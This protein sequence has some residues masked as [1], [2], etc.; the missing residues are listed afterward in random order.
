MKTVAVE[1]TSNIQ[2]SAAGGGAPQDAMRRNVE[3][4]Q[5]TLGPELTSLGI[6]LAFKEGDREGDLER[7]PSPLRVN[8]RALEEV[9]PEV[10]VC[11]RTTAGGAGGAGNGAGGWVITAEGSE[12]DVIPI[13]LIRRA[14]LAAAGLMQPLRPSSGGPA[15]DISNQRRFSW[16]SWFS[17]RWQ[18]RRPSDS[19]PSSGI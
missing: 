8:E 3:A 7:P 5:D 13:F 2:D 15:P 19:T 17:G 4:V 10:R 1:W 16:N 9:L 11:W 12:Y 18:R 14:V 6:R